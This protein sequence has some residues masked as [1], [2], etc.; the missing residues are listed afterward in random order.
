LRLLRSR[1]KFG[2]QPIPCAPGFYSRRSH[3]SSELCC[4]FLQEGRDG[5]HSRQVCVQDSC[6]LETAL[7]RLSPRRSQRSLVKASARS[8]RRGY[9]ARTSRSCCCSHSGRNACPLHG[10]TGADAPDAGTTYP[11]CCDR[12][13]RSAAHG[14]SA[15][16]SIGLVEMVQSVV[17]DEAAA[18][19]FQ[20]R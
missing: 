14:F 4:R 5:L 8:L 20:P 6:G 9:S 11:G 17:P 2:Y 19:R 18:M 3:L 1:I 10:C 13:V 12:C 16:L 15:G 7:I